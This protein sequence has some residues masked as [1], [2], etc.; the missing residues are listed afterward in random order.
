M[1]P[2]RA[3][4]VLACRNSNRRRH[5]RAEIHSR[6][7]SKGVPLRDFESDPLISRMIVRD[8]EGYPLPQGHSREVL[9]AFRS[10]YEPHVGKKQQAKLAN[11]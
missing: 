6:Q 2:F 4:T 10:R 11:R 5:E 7:I 8:E 3:Y 1:M 9:R